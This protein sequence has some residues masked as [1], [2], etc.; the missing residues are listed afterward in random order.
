M[1]LTNASGNLTDFQ[2]HLLDFQNA[3][4]FTSK[5]LFNEGESESESGNSEN[6]GS[7]EEGRNGSEGNSTSDEIR[8]PWKKKL[9]D[10]AAKYRVEA[11]EARVA[12]DAAEKR[13]REYE[14][15][16]R[17]DQEKAERDRDEFKGQAEKLSVIIADQAVKLAFFESG[18][19][20]LFRNPATALKILDLSGI[21][22]DKN[23]IVDADA[24][25]QRSEA[26]LKSD[27]YLAI[28]NESGEE[29]S[30]S[31]KNEP[32]G[33]QMNGNRNNQRELDEQ[34]ILA[35]FPTLRR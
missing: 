10:E 19:A 3:F 1:D 11:N 30:S 26:L 34:A 16:N 28:D 25:K 15:K 14:D 35:K 20:S 29:G 6:S 5:V 21:D 32:S 18:S 8:N 33:R 12:K 2:S 7:G 23:G 9:S 24:V 17:T 27:P 4:D 22:P 13:I 31:S